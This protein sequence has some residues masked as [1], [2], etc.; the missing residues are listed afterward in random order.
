MAHPGA[1]PGLRHTSRLLVDESL[2]VPAVSDAL[3]SFADMPPVFATAYL[4]A[5]V[6]DTCIEAVAPLLPEGTRTVVP[7]W[8]SGTARRPPLA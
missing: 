3:S 8:S 7:T 4:I 2:I 5:F 1:Q 6:E